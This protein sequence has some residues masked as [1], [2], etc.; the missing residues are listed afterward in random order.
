MSVEAEMVVVEVVGMRGWGNEGMELGGE[1]RS[2]EAMGWRSLVSLRSLGITARSL[3][4][5]SGS[6]QGAILRAGQTRTGRT[7]DSV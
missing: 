3:G 7:V 6:V 5:T 1:C 4:M 2:L